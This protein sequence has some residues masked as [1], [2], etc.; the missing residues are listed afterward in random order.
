LSV[1]KFAD[2]VVFPI[3]SEQ[4]LVEILESDTQPTAVWIGGELRAGPPA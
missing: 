1:G 3:R 4:P 2:F